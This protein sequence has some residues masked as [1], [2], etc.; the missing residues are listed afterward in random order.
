[1][2]PEDWQ[3]EAGRLLGVR[4]AL[5]LDEARAEVS[6]LLINTGSEARSFQL[7]QPQFHWTL[8]VDSASG[9]LND[10]EIDRPQLEV[11]A[12]S[13]QLLTSVV[14]APSPPDVT[15]LHSD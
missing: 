2:R 14:E 7:P 11:A 6:L 8:R 9:A 15:D 4:R 10:R 13:L 12:H 5:R 3:Y 1:M